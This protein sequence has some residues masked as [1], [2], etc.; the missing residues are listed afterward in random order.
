MSS[1]FL[2]TI[3]SENM[4]D[5]KGRGCILTLMSVKI[6]C[7]YDKMCMLGLKKIGDLFLENRM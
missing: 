3:I 7:F 4:I 5:L 1:F 6:R 2:A